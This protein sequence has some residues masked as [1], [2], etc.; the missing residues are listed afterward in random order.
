MSDAFDEKKGLIKQSAIKTLSRYGIHKTT[1]EDIAANVGIKKNSLYYYYES[2]E[3]LINE[4][5]E[6]EFEQFHNNLRKKL[7]NK[8][9]SE[10]IREYVR[11][12]MGFGFDRMKQLSTSVSTYFEILRMVEGNFYEL[13]E[14]IDCVLIS[15]LR[16]GISLGHFIEHDVKKL[17]RAINQMIKSMESRLIIFNEADFLT[18]LDMNKNTDSALL[19]IEYVITGLEKK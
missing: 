4:I 13:I 19:I 11:L 15:I 9:S 5:I 10:K 16:E 6:E 18:D 12:S 1:M 8:N 3:A 2:K 7:E 14:K 17:A